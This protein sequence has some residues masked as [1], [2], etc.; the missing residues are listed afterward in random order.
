[1]KDAR[2]EYRIIGR[3][4][5]EEKYHVVDWSPKWTDAD[6]QRRL[7]ELIEEGERE[8]ARGG[9]TTVAGSIGISTPYNPD[10]ALVDLKIQTRQ[11]TAWTI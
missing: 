10:Y 11:V 5:K 4:A 8:K 6:A 3:F 7:A 9:T 2:T 1:M